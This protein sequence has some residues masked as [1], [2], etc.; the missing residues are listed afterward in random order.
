MT[1]LYPCRWCK[2]KYKG[3]SAVQNA[4]VTTFKSRFFQVSSNIET[5][6]VFVSFVSFLWEKDR[7]W[8]SEHSK[9]SYLSI[10]T[11]V[12]DLCPPRTLAEK[13]RKQFLVWTGSYQFLGDFVG[14]DS[15][16]LLPVFLAEV[17]ECASLSFSCLCS[18]VESCISLVTLF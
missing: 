17:Q 15:L 5:W 2:E 16:L 14:C 6:I 18:P 3:I 9:T 10:D 11:L 1:T 13:F 8:I 12:G 7:S 4:H